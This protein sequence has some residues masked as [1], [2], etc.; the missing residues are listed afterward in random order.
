M[1]SDNADNSD[2]SDKRY[3]GD[4][5]MSKCT[6][7]W[8]VSEG[9]D[10]KWRCT[11][12][13]LT[14]PVLGERLERCYD[15]RC[16]GR[17]DFTLVE[18]IED[19]MKKNIK[20]CENPGCDKDALEGRKYCSDICMKRKYEKGRKR[21]RRK[22]EVIVEEILVGREVIVGKDLLSLSYDKGAHGDLVLFIKEEAGRLGV[23]EFEIVRR[24][25]SLYRGLLLRR[26]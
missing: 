10:L 13:L 18:R 20:G 8:S 4:F 12:Y 3:L 5:V 26:G 9:G 11:R 14:P 21:N 19:N 24:A 7:N 22:G 1:Y 25:V 15:H 17:R 23:E 16:P 6:V 2:N